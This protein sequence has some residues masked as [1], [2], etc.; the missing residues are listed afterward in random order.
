MKT[1]FPVVLTLFILSLIPDN[2]YSQK[3]ITSYVNY[4]ENY[5][6]LA[7]THMDK[8]KI[9]ASITLAQGILESGAGLSELARKSNNHFGIKCHKDWKGETV[10]ANDD[11]PNECFRK[12]KKVEDSYDDHSQFL[13][14]NR[15]SR[16]FQLDIKDYKAW[17]RGLQECGYATDRGYA[18]KL[19]NLIEVYEL[20]RYDSK[21]S[22]SFSS[23]DNKKDSGKIE[24]PRKNRQIFKSSGLLYVEAGV[25]DSFDAI[26]YDLGFKVKDL[27]KYNE[28]PEDFPLYKDDVVYLEKKKKKADKPHYEHIVR[29]GESMHGISQIYGIQLSRLYKMNKKDSDYVP[30]EGDVLRLR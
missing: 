30:E 12:Y 2:L 7:I 28:V 27:I 20:Y 8:Y 13:L 22:G 11:R 18:N 3:K 10:R 4:I 16:L 24:R 26:A 5:G 17:A 29:V 9:P 19:I 25:D 21:K 15:Y 23:K 1:Y 6:D 14:K